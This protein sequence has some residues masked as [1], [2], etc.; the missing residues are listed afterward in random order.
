MIFYVTF[1]YFQFR[2]FFPYFSSLSFPFFFLQFLHFSKQDHH[3]SQKRKTYVKN[4]TNHYFFGRWANKFCT[5]L[6]KHVLI[7]FE[8]KLCKKIQQIMAFLAHMLI[9]FVPTLKKNILK[10]LK[11]KKLLTFFCRPIM[12]FWVH[13]LTNVQLNSNTYL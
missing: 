7:F 9:N 10:N 11:K 5:H 4:L 8:K 1:F 13:G 6:Q 12:A 2:G 3:G